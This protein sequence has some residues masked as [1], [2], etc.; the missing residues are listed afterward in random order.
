MSENTGGRPSIFTQ[1]LADELCAQLAEGR[2]LRSVC[3]ADHMPSKATVF[4]WMRTHKG[5][6]DQY[7]RAKQEAADAL[8]DEIQDIADDGTN[9]WMEKLDSEGQPIGWQLNGEHVQRSKLRI[10]ARKWMASKMKPKV[11]GDRQI[12]DHNI[13]VNAAEDAMEAAM[14]RAAAAKAA[15]EQ[16]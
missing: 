10:D 8:F 11:Y 6:L 13:D 7:T 3:Q 12:I 9:D 4:N 5:F 2:S 16:D 14:K 1:E 15:I